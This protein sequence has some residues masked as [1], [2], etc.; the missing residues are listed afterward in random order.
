VWPTSLCD[1][2]WAEDY[3][4]QWYDGKLWGFKHLFKALLLERGMFKTD[5]ETKE[6]WYQRC[7]DKALTSKLLGGKIHAKKTKAA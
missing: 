4:T 7:K 1:T 6:E 5:D 3:S 2:C